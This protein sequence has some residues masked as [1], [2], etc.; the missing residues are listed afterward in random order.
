MVAHV[1]CAQGP[2]PRIR[3]ELKVMTSNNFPTGTIPANTGRMS[4]KP[5]LDSTRRDHP[6][7]YGENSLQ[8]SG[9]GPHEGPSPRIRGECW[10]PNVNTVRCGTIPAN[11]GR[12]NPEAP[13]C[14]VF[15][16]H[17]REYGENGKLS[18][19]VVEAVGTI[20][21][22]TGRIECVAGF[23]REYGDHPREYGEN[24]I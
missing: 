3:G 16:D 11:T 2:S 19:G 17:P 12:M 24:C 23:R 6:R 7:E 21:A 10:K 22:N 14:T 8:R 1:H 9:L 15:W 5:G 20:P 4:G 13:S 18:R